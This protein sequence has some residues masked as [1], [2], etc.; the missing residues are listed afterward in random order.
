MTF[1]DYFSRK[2]WVYFMKYKFEVSSKFK[3]WKVEVENQAGRKIKYLWSNNGIEYTYKKFIHFCEENGI[4][5][6][7]Y[8]RKTP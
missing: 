4:Q 7:F 5:R 8:V 3:L 2:V 6:K 1:T